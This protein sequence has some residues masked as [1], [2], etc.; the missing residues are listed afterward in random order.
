MG[1]IAIGAKTF[2]YPMP[3]TLVGANVSGKPT[4]Q[5]IAYCGI[6]SG[7]RI[8]K[9]M[10]FD[11]GYGKLKTAPMIHECPLNLACQLVQT[12]DYGGSAEIFIGEIVEAYA[13]KQYLTDGL[14]DITKIKPIIFSMHD[15]TRWKLGEPL[16]HALS[17]G[18]KFIARR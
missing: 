14:P 4:Y 11:T 2:L 5:T 10:L 7:R 8:D 13:E 16:A 1:K 17:I 18:K 6:V 12:L 9:S 3:T 15:N